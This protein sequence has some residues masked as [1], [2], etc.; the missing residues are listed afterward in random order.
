MKSCLIP[1]N[2]IFMINMASKGYRKV[3]MNMVDLAQM[4]FSRTFL[5][6]VFS[7][8]E[9]AAE[10]GNAREERTRSTHSSRCTPENNR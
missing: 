8:W 4:T 7:E 1:R 2:G 9:G 5:E 6:V 3:S 10:Q